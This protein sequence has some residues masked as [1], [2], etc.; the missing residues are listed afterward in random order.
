MDKQGNQKR[1]IIKRKQIENLELKNTIAEKTNSLR[2]FNSRFEQAAERI[3]ELKDRVIEIT[4][5]N[6]KKKEFKN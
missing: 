4:Q 5:S 6:Q 3:S 2:G 1:E